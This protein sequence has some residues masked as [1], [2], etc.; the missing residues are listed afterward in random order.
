MTKLGKLEKVSVRS[1]WPNEASHFTPWLAREE[2]IRLLGEEINIDLEVQMQEER[3]GPFRAD[4]LCQDTTNERYVLIENQ[5]ETTDHKHL[6]QLMT[7]AAGL[8]ALTII[9]ISEK[10]TDEHRAALDWLNRI[11]DDSVD[12]FG[13]EIELFR[14]GDSM[15]APMFNIVSK[16]NNW[17]KNI[18]RTAESSRITETKLI[19]QEYWQELKIFVEKNSKSSF[20]MQKPLPQHWTNIALGRSKFRLVLFANSRYKRIGCY[21]RTSGPNALVHFQKLRMQWE[22]DSKANLDPRVEWEEKEDGKEH[23]VIVRL[24]GQDPLD[25]SSW[26]QQHELLANLAERFVTYFK[27]KIREV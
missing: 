2:N 23:H 4:I 26:T 9:W 22:E 14:I 10:F 27:D 5:F 13:I 25:R 18:K 3:V 19:Q 11:T 17:S 12:F 6:G 15:P 1:I 16:P 24:T 20:R 21:L 7:Y 8:N